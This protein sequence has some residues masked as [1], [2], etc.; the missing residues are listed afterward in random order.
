MFFLKKEQTGLPH[1]S[2]HLK[3]HSVKCPTTSV[4]IMLVEEVE[5]LQTNS[6]VTGSVAE[7][8]E[9]MGLA[10]LHPKVL[11]AALSFFEYPTCWSWGC[12]LQFRVQ[13]AC[14]AL[15]KRLCR[16]NSHNSFRSRSAC[17]LSRQV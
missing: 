4:E 7:T 13:H 2:Y 10:Q 9:P 16:L 12:F 1:Q 17:V 11:A 15:P 6:R 3:C 14:D 5:T 8:T